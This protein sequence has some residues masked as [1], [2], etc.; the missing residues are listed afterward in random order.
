MNIEIALNERLTRKK[1]NGCWPETPLKELLDKINTETIKIAESRDVITAKTKEEA[2]DLHFP[3]YD[4][5]K[6]KGLDQFAVKFNKDILEIPHHLAHANVALA[7]GPF[8]ESI[9]VVLDG[10]GSRYADFTSLW[11][12][13]FPPAF[14]SAHEECT[15]YLQERNKLTEVTK[16]WHRFTQGKNN[17]K[18]S[19]SDGV[20]ILYEKA[21]EYIFGSNQA[22]G[23]VMGLASFGK[24]CPIGDYVEYLD[25]LDW[26][27]SYTG[28]EK[29]D[30]ES[31]PYLK[32]YMDI[33]ASVQMA[34]EAHLDKVLTKAKKD[35]PQFENL[36]LVGGCALNCSYNKKL[37]DSSLYENVYVPAFPGDGGLSF[38]IAHFLLYQDHPEYWF[39]KPTS[40]QH[41]YYGPCSSVP[42]SAE[43]EE[44]FKGFNII[45]PSSILEHTSSIITKGGVV[46]WFQGRSESGPRSLGNRSI[47]ASISKHNLKDYLNTHIKFRE[48]FRPY[49]CSCLSEYAGLYFDIPRGFSNP[50]MS[51]AIDVKDEFKDTFKEVSHID[52]T[53][54]MQT[55]SKEQNSMFHE[56]LKVHG[57]NTGIYALA[58]TSLNI[59]G[60]PIVETIE[61]VR[62]FLEATKVDGLIIGD[63]YV[64]K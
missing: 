14:S 4:F 26:S 61:D 56:L 63:Y 47:L 22:S 50:Y 12:S 58:N 17:P 39:P 6:K 57:D 18:H 27:K 64:W 37:L 10:S 40:E 16:Y 45:R 53:S 48:S 41:G 38:G 35:F 28:T 19:F 55:V 49:G 42:E 7:T 29:E 51:Y 52:G 2:L 23:K 59:M 36:I 5:L 24:A 32:H 54:R 3:F 9:I 34:Y 30:W 13:S 31:S 43:I 11:E 15:I 44:V 46:A 8:E 20:G 21:A 62:R 25:N 60:E 33:A 1:A